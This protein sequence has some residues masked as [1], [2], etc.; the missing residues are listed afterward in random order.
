MV[1]PHITLPEDF[2]ERLFQ[3]DMHR[4][5][6]Q[7]DLPEAANDLDPES[8]EGLLMLALMKRQKKR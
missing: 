1:V 3:R 5:G 4:D 7:V 6:W 2:L 8:P